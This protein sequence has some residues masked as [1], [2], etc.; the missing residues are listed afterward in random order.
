MDLGLHFHPIVLLLLQQ[1]RLEALRVFLGKFNIAEHDFFDNDA[2][3]R[4]SLA[5]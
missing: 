3:D 5:N 2:V 1:Q 4:K